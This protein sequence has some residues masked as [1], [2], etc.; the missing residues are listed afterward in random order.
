[1]KKRIILS[2]LFAI[3]SLILIIYFIN[4][5]QL[6]GAIIKFILLSGI[7]FAELTFI[8][9]SYKEKLL[10]KRS[11]I[12]L[13]LAWLVFI[14]SFNY[15]SSFLNPNN[16]T[17]SMFQMDSEMLV[18]NM[19]HAK[20]DGENYT[21]PYG[22]GLYYDRDS[23]NISSYISSYGLQG[24]LFQILHKVHIK[25]I[26]C[27]VLTAFVFVIICFL[28]YKKYG[29]LFA[30]CFY[31]TFLLS[32]WSVN[33]ARN[34]YWVEFTWFVPMMLGLICSIYGEKKRLI[35]LE[36][37]AGAFLSIFIKSLCGY[38]YLSVIM[39]SMI[40][41]MSSELFIDITK[42]NWNS[43]CRR[44][45]SIFFMGICALVGFGVALLLHARIR[46]NGNILDGLN[47][48]YK[49]DVLR[50]TLGGHVE[51]FD[52]VYMK[53]LQASVIDVLKIYFNNWFTEII[54][55]I[56]G[57]YFGFLILMPLIIFMYR[58]VK[59]KL[60][61]QK[62]FLYFIFLVTCTSWFVLGKAHSYLHAH[63][64]YVLWYFGYIQVCFYIIIDE[65]IN[66][67]RTFLFP[68]VREMFSK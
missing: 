50:R 32:P 62:V 28:I 4:I 46:G 27:I 61:M 54:S 38:E 67:C 24:K 47:L 60:E 21:G 7:V 11:R 14:M 39:L 15:S 29:L 53:S 40:A 17:F 2:F 45:K 64:N 22:L 68:K 10:T 31:I 42:K 51:D 3:L 55:C 23:G 8:I 20:N 66:Y 13:F 56:S 33:F 37:Y 30:I 18:M 34:L 44:A 59:G 65:I 19:I 25:H 43:S 36:C 58:T 1:M 5:G 48:I 57:R 16:N 63:I 12:V 41:F 9:L 6:N 52:P 26:L 49:Q 35:R